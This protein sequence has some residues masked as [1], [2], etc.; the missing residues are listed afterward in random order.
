MICLRKYDAWGHCNHDFKSFAHLTFLTEQFKSLF[1]SFNTFW[2]YRLLHYITSTR[3]LAPKSNDLWNRCI[4][5]LIKKK[6]FTLQFNHSESCLALSCRSL[7][8][9][10]VT[11]TVGTLRCPV[12]SD[13]FWNASRAW[14]STRFPLTTTPSMSRS[15]PKFGWK[16][17][18]DHQISLWGVEKQ[19]KH[20][21]CVV[22]PVYGVTLEKHDQEWIMLSL[23]WTMIKLIAANT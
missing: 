20:T 1:C 19:M 18:G 8:P 23:S 11:K 7:L 12:W 10:L 15:R 13:N 5:F 3:K 9:A 2:H 14:G 6:H 17:K 16:R 22:F 21:S 4:I